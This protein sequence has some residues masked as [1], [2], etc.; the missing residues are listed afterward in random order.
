MWSAVAFVHL[1]FIFKLTIMEFMREI[2]QIV[3]IALLLVLVISVVKFF[4]GY[5][6][7]G[8]FTAGANKLSLMTLIFM[9]T[10][11]LLGLG[12]Y[13]S[14]A[15]YQALK[16]DFSHA[17]STTEIREMAIEH[18][19]VGIL[20]AVLITMGRSRAKKRT[21]DSSKYAQHLLFF[22]LGF[23][24]ILSRIPWKQLFELPFA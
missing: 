16:A 6:K 14:S 9:H 3:A 23:L 1:L 18:P 15:P 4:L 21:E 8:A 22:G 7:K 11:V 20:A 24:L 12:V 17:M 19:L 2:H 13:F 10:Q 5:S